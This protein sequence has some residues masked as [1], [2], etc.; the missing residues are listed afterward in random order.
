MSIV[1]SPSGI[2]IENCPFLSEIV[3]RLLP[4]T[5]MVAEGSVIPSS[6]RM[7]PFMVRIAGM[8]IVFFFVIMMV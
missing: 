7:T 2:R 4:F 5:K 8:G 3:P 6:S 1:F